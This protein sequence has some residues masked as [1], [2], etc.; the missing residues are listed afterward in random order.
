MLDFDD[1]K[2]RS[3][4]LEAEVGDDGEAYA[5]GDSLLDELEDD[6]P[7][8]DTEDEDD[9]VDDEDEDDERDEDPLYEPDW[10]SED[11]ES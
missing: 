3:A 8:F 10:D 1:L 9:F 2:A 5:L 6:E 11:Y 7:E 4:E